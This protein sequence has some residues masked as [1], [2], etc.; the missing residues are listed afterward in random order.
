MPRRLSDASLKLVTLLI[1]AETWPRP[2]WS[3]VTLGEIEEGWLLGELALCCLLG[4]LPPPS[5]SSCARRD[6]GNVIFLPHVAGIRRI[7]SDRPTCAC[8]RG[9][10]DVLPSLPLSLQSLEHASYVAALCGGSGR[11]RRRRGG[12]REEERRFDIGERTHVMSTNFWNLEKLPFSQS[13]ECMDGHS[14]PC[15][16][17]HNERLLCMP[18]NDKSRAP[19]IQWV[20]GT[21]ERNIL[22]NAQNDSLGRRSPSKTE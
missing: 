11:T 14:D 19:E 8:V 20:A 6:T 4:A 3:T 22:R 2:I 5:V 16:P 9:C 18:Y 15:R 1:C 13:T 12:V 21:R 10:A 17:A 7:P